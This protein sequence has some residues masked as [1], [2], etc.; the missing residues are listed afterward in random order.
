MFLHN[1]RSVQVQIANQMGL[2]KKTTA[3][4]V[5]WV[6][7]CF[8]VS[9]AWYRLSKN[10][11]LFYCY[12]FPRLQSS[13]ACVWVPAAWVKVKVMVTIDGQSL[14]V[15]CTHLWPKTK[16]LLLLLLLLLTV[17][18][19]L[20]WGKISD[21]RTGLSFTVAAGP[22]QRS[23]SRI[24]VSLDSWPYSIVSDSRLPNLEGQVP[25]FTSRW[26]RVIRLF[27]QALG[28]LFAA[29]YDSQGYG[30]RFDPP[31]KAPR[32]IR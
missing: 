25:A 31:P 32:Y 16:L 10:S 4:K 28:S 29:S 7:Y 2:Q 22:R 14:L 15:S 6:R 23:N 20:T 17:V 12:R 11:D 13:L 19:L 3:R 24:R 18:G 5:S 1:L 27:P 26:N 9:V 30:G 8:H 21:E